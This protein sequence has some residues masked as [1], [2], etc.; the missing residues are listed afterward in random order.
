MQT[1]SWF[2]VYKR[3]RRDT[4]SFMGKAD[5]D[6]IHSF[7]KEASVDQADAF[8]RLTEY[9]LNIACIAVNE[10]S[11]GAAS[12]ETILLYP[13]IHH[14]AVDTD[15]LLSSLQALTRDLL[16][17][18]CRIE[19]LYA[20]TA[21]I[22]TEN[23]SML[24]MT[25]AKD[26]RVIFIVLARRLYQMRHI[27]HYSPTQQLEI[28]R[29]TVFLYAPLAHR[30]GL[31]PVK[32]ELEERS[33]QI[34]FPDIYAQLQEKL[35]QTEQQRDLY[36]KHFVAPLK[37]KLTA[38]GL[39]YSLKSR[40]KSIP[41]IWNKMKKQNVP[42]EG[43]YDL[44]AIRI[45]LDCSLEQEKACC[46]QVYSIVTDMYTPDIRR[47][48]DWLSCPKA[49]GYESLHTTVM[50]GDGK[51][52]EVQ[53]RTKRMDE[54][55]EKGLA[56]HWRYKGIQGEAKMDAWLS[57]LRQ[58]LET[59]GLSNREAMDE[60]KLN[61]YDEQVFVFTPKGDLHKLPK[62]ATLLDF[63]FA[64][65]TAV[66]EHCIGGRIGNRNVTLRYE[67]QN[68]DQIEIITAPTQKPRP[69]WLGWVKT[70]K[71]KQK[72]RQVLT[73]HETHEAAQGREMLLRRF[74]N[75]KTELDEGR[76]AQLTTEMG[77]KNI[78][79]FY[80]LVA[81]QQIDLLDF[82]ERYLHFDELK[83]QPTKEL[84]NTDTYRRPGNEDDVLII[85]DNTKG[86]LYSM[87][88][89]CHPIFGDEVF[90]FVTVNNGIKIHRKDCPN[91]S[92]MMQRYGYRVVR[93]SWEA[94]GSEQ[95]ICPI[96]LRGA[97]NLGL[98]TNIQFVIQKETGVSLRSVQINNL[99]DS[100]EVR[101]NLTVSDTHV[102]EQIIR[103]LRDIKGVFEVSRS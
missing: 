40:T 79:R 78:N 57:S 18:L 43:V 14:K 24:L 89:C 48:R 63:A 37:E 56:A 21:A 7:Y 103:K 80:Q 55:A 10:L 98:M 4:A 17:G 5:F 30:M 67:L 77:Y 23:F 22:E 85:S 61:L 69:D 26:V 8:M 3:L 66:G 36:I 101:L 83:T 84:Q 12:V 39:N 53:I 47:M 100:M 11:L 62:G 44:F 68:G 52:I 31:Y 41:S 90:G 35:R 87:A 16:N 50:G 99:G 65:H 54:I 2:S 60:F 74:K 9:A 27:N 25:L 20:K 97:D 1:A 49:N 15:K 58:A 82:R 88:K 33:M 93:A 73:E 95:H 75:W 42:F 45:I 70:G 32:T 94:K 92:Q 34:Q 96:Y 91:A 59:P 64:I 38:A 51:Y 46:W 102:L 71:A 81:E 6:R 28:A 13:L 72:I 76:M 86:V 19:S 29:E